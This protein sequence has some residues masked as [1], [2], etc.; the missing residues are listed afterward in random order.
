MFQKLLH[1]LFNKKARPA[2]DTA[3][4]LPLL[5][6]LTTLTGKGFEFL[7]TPGDLDIPA[8]DFDGLMTPDSFRWTKM[9]KDNWP[10]Y[11]IDD[12][13]FTYSW[14]PPGIQMTF[15]ANIP[16]TKAKVIADEV[17]R[18]LAAYTGQS[19]ELVIISGD[20]PILFDDTRQLPVASFQIKAACQLTGRSFFLLG[21]ILSGKIQKGMTVDLH[22]IG[23]DKKLVLE[24]IE[25]AL[26]RE[27]GKVWED[28][29]LGIS[30]VTEGEKELLKAGS[31]FSQPILLIKGMYL[32][33]VE[34]T[35]VITGRGLVLYP[36]FG[37]NMAK[38]GSKITLIRPDQ[39]VIETLIRGISF[40]ENHDILVGENVKKEDVP[41]GT[42]VWLQK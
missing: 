25:F 26:H 12:D 19:I 24:A 36:G 2:A 40:S 9:I 31:P 4:S 32:F 37:N 6:D 1:R 14:E 15:S 42:E 16:Y 8:A 27:E 22:P 10:Y 20:V 38:I 39:S 5:A 13:E 17:V 35:F 34:A 7:I 28:V 29:G 41:I 30:G 33:T 3:A 11:Q 18:K 23:V 21:E